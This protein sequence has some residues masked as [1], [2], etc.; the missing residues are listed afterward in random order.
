M[1]WNPISTRTR[2]VCLLAAAFFLAGLAP[3]C[4]KKKPK[5][6]EKPKVEKTNWKAKWAKVFA[7]G[8]EGKWWIKQGFNTLQGA[9]TDEA[10]G[11]AFDKMIKGYK[12]IM[13]AIQM[14]EEVVEAAEAKD[15]GESFPEWE[16]DLASWTE[17]AS[18]VRKSSGMPMEYIEKMNK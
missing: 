10:R 17:E 8:E 9:T 11:E 12:Q 4:G 3:G 14:G 15:K 1:G 16:R 5:K 7:E 6:I 18:K 2:C 13:K